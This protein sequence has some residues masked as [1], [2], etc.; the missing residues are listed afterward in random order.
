VSIATPLCCFFFSLFFFPRRDY[1]KLL[2]AK[3]KNCWYFAVGKDEEKT[4]RKKK[5][6]ERGVSLLGVCFTY[7][8]RLYWE[9]R[10]VTFCLVFVV[11]FQ[12]IFSSSFNRWNTDKKKE[13][14][15]SHDG[16]LR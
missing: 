4:I 6:G 8:K 16:G 7:G 3:E 12:I 5:N 15:Q 2:F 11:L 10:M 14:L 9:E 1:T 13:R